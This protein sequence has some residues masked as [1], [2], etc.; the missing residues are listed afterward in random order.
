MIKF[1]IIATM[2]YAPDD[3]KF[4]AINHRNK[5]EVFVSRLCTNTEFKDEA[6]CREEEEDSPSGKTTLKQK[7][8]PSL[9]QRGDTGSRIKARIGRAT[10]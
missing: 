2:L 4:T 7:D 10:T 8:E 3:Y 9:A 5:T 1:L 6:R